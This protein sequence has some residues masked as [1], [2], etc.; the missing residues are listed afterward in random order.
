[1]TAYAL[2]FLFLAACIQE[3]DTCGMRVRK[4][5]KSGDRRYAETRRYSQV[6]F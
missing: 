5:L 1:M 4:D 3:L 6:N 2:L